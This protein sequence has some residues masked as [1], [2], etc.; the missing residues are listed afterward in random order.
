MFVC[1]SCGQNGALPSL[2]TL[3][4]LR[5]GRKLHLRVKSVGVPGGSG[6]GRVPTGTYDRTPDTSKTAMS[7]DAITAMS[8]GC[9]VTF[10]MH[11][12]SAVWLALP[13]VKFL[14]CQRLCRVQKHGNRQLQRVK[15]GS[16]G[17]QPN[18]PKA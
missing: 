16:N 6:W 18:P 12:N 13:G 2:S 14:T 17:L 4:S 1:V 15:K 9:A 11:R 8:P 3:K 10:R 7:P 5:T